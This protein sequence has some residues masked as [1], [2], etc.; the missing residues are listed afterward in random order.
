MNLTIADDPV[1]LAATRVADRLLSAARVRG[2][3]VLAVPGGS[4]PGPILN[5]LRDEDPGLLRGLTVTLVDERHLPVD[6]PATASNWRQLP[7]DSNTRLLYAE[8]VHDA[9][10]APKVVGW[11]RPGDLSDAVAHLELA[12]PDPDVLLIGMGPDGHIASLFPG[13]D[14]QQSTDRIASLIDSPKP[15]AE[16]LTMG[17]S[18]LNRALSA[19]VVVRGAAKAEAVRRA[20][21]R[22][23]TLPTTH[24]TVPEIHWFLD[25]AAAA[26]LPENP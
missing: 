10:V 3:M 11:S 12:V 25:P 16:R 22:D 9:P 7:A 15:P 23:P 1:G 13:H 19:V 26:H 14:V 8:L 24:L 5:V 18:L 2:S 21:E 6:A 20:Y 4:T 17:L